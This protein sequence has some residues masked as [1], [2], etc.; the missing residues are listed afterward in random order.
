[1]LHPDY[2]L[3]VE[4]VLVE[5][6]SGMLRLARAADKREAAAEAEAATPLRTELLPAAPNPFNPQTRLGFT[7]AQ[8][9]RIDLPVYDLRG[10]KVATL[11][12]GHYAAGPHVLTWQGRDDSGHSAA[13]GLYLAK[14]AA[15]GLELTQRLTLVR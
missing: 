1:M 2:R 14:L 8:A 4:P 10:R 7:L 3:A 15:D 13:S 5:A 9:G 11:A 6:N 12:S